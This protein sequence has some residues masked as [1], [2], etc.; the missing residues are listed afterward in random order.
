MTSQMQQAQRRDRW[1][2]WLVV[3]VFVLALILGWVVK[4]AAEGRTEAFTADGLSGRFPAAWYRPQVQD[5]VIFEARDRLADP[6]PTALMVERRP[7]DTLP[8]IQQALALERG[9]NWNAYRTLQIVE[10]ATVGGRTGMQ[11]TFA[12]V[13]TNPNPF[14]K[15]APVVLMG[16]DLIFP[17]ADGN[18]VY[19]VTLTAAEENFDSALKVWPAFIASLSE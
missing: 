6:Y 16:T 9:R 11:V 14:M 19:V 2:S 3:G 8:A 12:Y 18:S 15:T 17:A 1:V 13:E 7:A 5:P 10:S 4:T